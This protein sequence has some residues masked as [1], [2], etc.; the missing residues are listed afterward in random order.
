MQQRAVGHNFIEMTM[1]RVCNLLAFLLIVRSDAFNLFKGADAA[2]EEQQELDLS[3]TNS[4]KLVP[5]E[6]V[7]YGG[8]IAQSYNSVCCSCFFTYSS[9]E[10][11][12]SFLQSISAGLS[13]TILCQPITRGCL[14]SKCRN[15]KLGLG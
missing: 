6:S 12:N 11:N 9:N 7:E 8:E 5:D 15:G 10:T 2:A 4:G 13:I 1:V 3:V 14:T